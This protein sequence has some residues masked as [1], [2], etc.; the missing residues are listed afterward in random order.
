MKE[1]VKHLMIFLLAPIIILSLILLGVLQGCGEDHIPPAEPPADA[2]FIKGADI[3]YWLE[4]E[5]AGAVWKH[6]GIAQPLLDIL[7]NHGFNAIRLMTWHQPDNPAGYNDLAHLVEASVRVKKKGFRL[8]VDIFYNDGFFKGSIPR[9]WEGQDAAQLADSVYDYTK[10]IMTE[11]KN[12]GATPD[13]VQIGNEVDGGLLAPYGKVVWGY[14]EW[15]NIIIYDE[16]DNLANFFKKGIQAV[17]EVSPK[18]KTVVQLADGFKTNNEFFLNQIQKRGADF[19]IIGISAYPW[20]G[21]QSWHNVD[22]MSDLLALV[23]Y[24]IKARLGISSGLDL[25]KERMNY[26]AE[27]FNKD[28]LVCETAY[29]WTEEN[30]DSTPNLYHDEIVGYLGG[31]GDRY[32]VSPEGQYDFI[33]QFI[34]DIHTVPDNRGIGIFWWE[35]EW[36]PVPGVYANYE[37]KWEDEW[38][39]LTLFDFQGNAL[40]SMDAFLLQFS[41]APEFTSGSVSSQS[42][43]PQPGSS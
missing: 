11:L 2:T 20:Q 10:N 16:W 23:G 19:D 12:N 21:L 28:I 42:S 33:K 13:W 25:C 3:S 39:D 32:P 22:E 34:Y 9:A 37:K 15:D 24:L 18:T 4:L 31:P 5:E 6:N 43:P 7:K 36:Y 27:K 38:D 30:G 14:D 29:P 41:D 26:L 40:S 8:M 1:L 35:P 17:K